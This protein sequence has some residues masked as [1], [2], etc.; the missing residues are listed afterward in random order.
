MCKEPRDL[1]NA[2]NQPIGKVQCWYFHTTLWSSWYDSTTGVVGMASAS[3]TPQKIFDY[4]NK[5]K[6]Q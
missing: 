4:L 2:K 6:I 5:Y 1:L 3:T